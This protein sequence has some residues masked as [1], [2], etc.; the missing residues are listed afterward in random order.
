MTQKKH[1]GR[2]GCTDTDARIRSCLILT[3]SMELIAQR[4]KGFRF[5]GPTFLFGQRSRVSKP[6][7]YLLQGADS[8]TIISVP[9]EAYNR[10]P[11]G[12]SKKSHLT[13]F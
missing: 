2:D 5:E 3:Q 8:A 6:S 1:R 11:A 9:Q 4:R 12:T 13:S 7:G 10:V